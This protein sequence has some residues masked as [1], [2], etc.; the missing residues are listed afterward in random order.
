[1]EKGRVLLDVTKLLN[2]DTAVFANTSEVIAHQVDDHRILSP[3]FLAGQ[4]FR[5]ESSVFVCGLAASTRAF[6]RRGFDRALDIDR[7][8][9]GP[10]L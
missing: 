3:I 6:D 2:L 1:M 10:D 5:A 4:K 7:N 8:R 9:T